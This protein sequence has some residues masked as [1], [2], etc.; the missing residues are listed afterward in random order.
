MMIIRIEI[1]ERRKWDREAPG[2]L[3]MKKYEGSN[4][5]LVDFKNVN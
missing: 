1:K 4:L 2:P 3:Q 5:I